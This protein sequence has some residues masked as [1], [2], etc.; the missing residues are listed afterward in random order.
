MAETLTRTIRVTPEQWARIEKIA[1]DRDVS[2]NRLV[3]E[4]VMEALDRRE[5]PRTQLDIQVAKAALFA[6][7][8]LRRDLIAAGRKDEVEEILRFVAS[9]VPESAANPPV[10]PS[11][12]ASRFDPKQGSE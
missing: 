2:A 1:K 8:V 10:S 4:L 7:Q 11:L 6:A 12:P 9:L 3:V 5:W